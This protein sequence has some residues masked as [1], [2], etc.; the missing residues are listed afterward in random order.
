GINGGDYLVGRVLAGADDLNVDKSVDTH[1]DL[2]T[3]KKV[4]SLGMA[5]GICPDIP[6]MEGSYLMAGLAFD[7]WTKDQ[8]PN[9]AKP[10]GNPVKARTFAVA[11][12]ENLPK[13]EV[14]VG[15]GKIS[16]TPFCQANTA[17]G[18]TAT[19]AGWRSCSL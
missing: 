17:A 7:A 9:L 19:T 16:L 13:F 12:A 15:N 3:A 14:P 4:T 5:R 6:S 18:A 1:S 8:R 2:C 10:P 11:L